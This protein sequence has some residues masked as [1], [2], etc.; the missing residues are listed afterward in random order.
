M[1]KFDWAI[2]D[3]MQGIECYATSV[4]FQRDMNMVAW[5]RS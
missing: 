1:R 2:A 3:P 4:W 5:P